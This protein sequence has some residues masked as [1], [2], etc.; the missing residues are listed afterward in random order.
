[1]HCE[2]SMGQ[3][4]HPSLPICVFPTISPIPAHKQMWH[5]IYRGHETIN[6]HEEEEN[7]HLLAPTDTWLR[8]DSDHKHTWQLNYTPSA[9]FLFYLGDRNPCCLSDPRALKHGRLR[10]W[11]LLWVYTETF[12]KEKA[13]C[14]SYY[15]ADRNVDFF[16]R[17]RPRNHIR[18]G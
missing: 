13:I 1:M 2:T 5:I 10:S 7:G 12:N 3:W 11:L 17:C 16:M 4:P 9:R 18:N 6:F 14:T 8:V 15:Y